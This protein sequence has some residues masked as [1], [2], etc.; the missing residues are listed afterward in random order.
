MQSGHF[1]LLALIG[2]LTV[3]KQQISNKPEESKLVFAQDFLCS[4]QNLGLHSLIFVNEKLQDFPPKFQSAKA[5]M[6]ESEFC[7]FVPCAPKLKMLVEALWST[8]LDG[9]IGCLGYVFIIVHNDDLRGAFRKS[10]SSMPAW[11]FE[12]TGDETWNKDNL[13]SVLF[14]CLRLHC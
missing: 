2:Q 11:N 3:E 13:V 6:E 12:V 8:D 1:I 10:L 7:T 4:V 9:M 14:N 5:E